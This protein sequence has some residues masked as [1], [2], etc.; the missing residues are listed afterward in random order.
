LN[1]PAPLQRLLQ[2]ASAEPEVLHDWRARILSTI[3][4]F[5]TALGALAAV[6]SIW[7]AV[8]QQRWP[9]AWIDGLALAWVAILWRRPALPY[10]FRAWNLLLLIYLLGVWFLLN[11]GPAS[12]IYLM[13]FT[14]MAALLLGIRPA[15]LALAVNAVTLLG[16]GYLAHGDL[17]VPGFEERPFIEWTVITI[18]FLFVN[19]VITI[20]C[21]VLLSRLESSLERQRVA[22]RSLQEGQAHLRAVNEE[23]QRTAAALNRLAYFD[24][25]TGLPNRRLL[26]DR[27]A[28]A[29]S[30]AQRAPLGGVLLYLDLDRFKNI[31]DARG[32]AAGDA[33]LLAVAQRLAALMGQDDTVARLGG[34]EFVILS[35]LA[36]HPHEHAP[37][38]E[39]AHDGD[40][41]AAMVLAGKVR[42]AF[43]QPFVIDSQPYSVSTSIGVV[44][45]GDPDQ[46][47]EDVLRDADTAMYRAKGAGRNRIAFFEAAMQREV[48]QHLAMENDLAQAIAQ[49][50]LALHLQ[51]QVDAAGTV[52]G[53]ELLLR[54]T[55]PVLGAIPPSRFVP[56]AEET[57]L[58]VQLGNWVLEHACLTQRR[59]QAAGLDV[60]LSLNVSPRQFHQS[61]FVERVL[62][63]L[64]RSGADAR[65]LVFEVTEGLLLENLE[66]TIPRMEALAARGIRFSVDDFGTGYS[67]LAYLKRL[68]L[69]ELKIDRSFIQDTPTDPGDTAIVQMILSMARHLGLKVV[70]EGVQTRAQADFLAANGCDAMQGYLFSRPQPLEAWLDTPKQTASIF[71]SL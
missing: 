37:A 30:A 21:G 5:S 68:P 32:H 10:R 58:I 22:S 55:H 27:L 69:H 71:A 14:V 53:V 23:L 16:L 9:I 33:L 39:H 49:D 41:R 26:M 62:A 3:L 66:R 38:H 52:V 45:L 15:L 25:L 12:Q 67:S 34:D 64:D 35:N 17:H 28:H 48:E 44:V 51:S 60:P 59:L 40:A 54:W 6:P 61:D 18:N 19:A 31:N 8:H 36:A 20:S 42:D 1:L 7:L 4:L 29:Q 47:A 2:P 24:E 70:A 57:N 11:V 50:Q 13:A 43:E 56:I 46:S 63:V 65:M